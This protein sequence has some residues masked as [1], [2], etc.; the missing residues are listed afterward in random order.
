MASSVSKLMN[1][2]SKKIK[3]EDDINTLIILVHHNQIQIWLIMR[4]MIS[5]ILLKEIQRGET[6]DEKYW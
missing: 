6:W 2:V 3:V 4:V 5:N 1:E